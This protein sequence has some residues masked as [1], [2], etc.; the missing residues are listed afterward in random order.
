MFLFPFIFTLLKVRIMLKITILYGAIRTGRMSIRAARAV[1]KALLAT[2]Q[3]E[4]TFVD[5]R[6]YNLP[7]MEARLKDMVD[8]PARIVALGNIISGSDGIIM[9]SPEY[10]N[11]YSGAL[12][13][14]VDYFTK[15]WSHKP[16]GIV[17]A[18]SG[19]QG[20]INASNLMQLLGL[21]IMGFAVPVKLL[22]PE[23]EKSIDEEGNPLNEKMAK[24]IATFVKEFVWFTE[25]IA[26]QKKNKPL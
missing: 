5:I 20:G 22:V 2:G 13:N 26:N 4:I 25:A 7:V 1:Q 6:E 10:N 21:A 17:T 11:S 24:G 9:V 14:A 16:I 18:S 3:A 15:E 8:P 19:I 12:K 23:I